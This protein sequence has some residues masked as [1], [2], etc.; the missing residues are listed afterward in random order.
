MS[1]KPG[2]TI[3]LAA[4]KISASFARV[5]FPAGATSEISSPTRRISSTAS[6]LV[7]GS[8]TRP[9]LTRS[10]R[11]VLYIGGA[12]VS[13]LF[14]L[15]CRIRAI[16]R[17]AGDKQEEQRHAHGDAVGDLLE[18]ARLRAVGNFRRN[19]DTAIHGAGMKHDGIGLGPA[20]ALGIELVQQ[21]VIVR[22][23]RRFV[24]ALGLN[25]QNED[26]VGTFESFLD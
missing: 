9:F 12:A 24:E 10:M 22:G 20:K 11:C 17:D 23:E 7:A 4:S 2:A 8:R 21:D 14:R 3:R 19:F 16:L 1:I 26:Y 18:N 6:V 13:W 25:A 15:V 5:T